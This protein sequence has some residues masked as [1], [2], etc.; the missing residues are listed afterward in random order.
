MNWTE[1][2]LA[3]H[4]RASK[5]RTVL[6]RQKEHFAKSR[7]GLLNAKVKISP[8]VISFLAHPSHS[9]SPARPHSSKH[10]ASRSTSSSK[11]RPRG[12]DP[13]HR[14]HHFQDG[15]GL[16]LPTPDDFQKDLAEAEILCEKRRKLLLMGDWTGISL[17]KPIDIEFTRSRAS[18]DDP[19]GQPKSRHGKS[20][21]SRLRHMLEVSH[22]TAYGRTVRK[23]EAMD[24]HPF[25][26][27]QVKV[28]V[29]SREKAV[30]GSSNASP[31]SRTY[32]DEESS[33]QGMFLPSSIPHSLTGLPNLR[34]FLSSPRL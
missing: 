16:D 24:S 12:Q 17:Q 22:G 28:R 8:P 1:G 21:M 18:V 4:S 27:R 29:G 9:S 6:L 30:G 25:S 23:I 3:R 19:W 14:S 7:S 33:P 34:S 5:S 32:R 26:P 13:P 2:G 20:S 10:H 11:K 31:R 15:A